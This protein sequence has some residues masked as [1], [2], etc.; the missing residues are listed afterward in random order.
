MNPRNTSPSP[1]PTPFPKFLATSIATII[2]TPILTIGISIS[3]V[4]GESELLAVAHA[5]QQ[6][7]G[8]HLQH[9]NM[10]KLETLGAVDAVNPGD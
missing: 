8:H 7:T 6:V 3:R 10:D 9:P 2:A 5:Y 1:K 4:A